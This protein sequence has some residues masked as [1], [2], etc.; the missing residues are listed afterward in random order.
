MEEKIKHII[1]KLYRIPLV[2]KDL[3]TADSSIINWPFM[4]LFTIFFTAIFFIFVYVNNILYPIVLADY[5]SFTGLTITSW[6]LGISFALIVVILR[7]LFHFSAKRKLS[8]GWQ[9]A[10]FNIVDTLPKNPQVHMDKPL[11]STMQTQIKTDEDPQ[12]IANN[13][14][15]IT[16]K[17]DQPLPEVLDKNQAQV[18]PKKESDDG[19]T[20]KPDFASFATTFDS[21][22]QSHGLTGKNGHIFISLMVMSRMIVLED[23]PL[24]PEIIGALSKFMIGSTRILDGSL[25]AD[26]SIETLPAF[27]DVIKS[28]QRYPNEPQFVQIEG[29]D[30]LVLAKCFSGFPDYAFFPNRVYTINAQGETFSLPNNLWFVMSLK[31]GTSVFSI[32]T[33]IRQKIVVFKGGFEKIPDVK[34]SESKTFYHFN[35]LEAS[36]VLSPT[37][38]SPHLSEDLWK[39]VDQWTQIMTQVNQYDLNNETMIHLENAIITLLSLKVEPLVALDIIFSTALLVHALP[40]SAKDSYQKETDMQRFFE[41]TFG[42]KTFSFSI[43]LFNQ[44]KTWNG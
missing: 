40:R 6:T 28:A 19:V 18:E 37:F 23:Q 21:Y 11:S 41:S 22:M 16:K 34:P 1:R 39:K 33:P 13:L 29:I 5:Q 15:S 12:E 30:P 36:R 35:F 3:I 24:I 9:D 2:I 44:Y 25:F 32:P 4:V 14:V 7:G 17:P 20:I 8:V 43:S 31:K 42:R 10:E 27:I 38:P 26:Q